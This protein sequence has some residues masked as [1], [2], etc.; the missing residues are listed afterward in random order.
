MYLHYFSYNIDGLPA[1]VCQ[2][3]QLLLSIV[4]RTSVAGPATTIVV[5]VS[6]NALSELFELINKPIRVIG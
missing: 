6:K 3:F 5:V 1:E 2:L 4:A